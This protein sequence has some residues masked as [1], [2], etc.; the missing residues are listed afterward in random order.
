MTGF[1]WT[2][3]P[4][5]TFAEFGAVWDECNDRTSRSP[6][7]SSTFVGLA[8]KHFGDGTEQVAVAADERGTAAACLL[9][10]RGATVLETFQPSQLPIGPWLQRSDLGLAD[11]AASLLQSGAGHFVMASLTQLDPLLV[12]RPDDDGPIRTVPYIVTGSI[13]LP[14][15]LDE[16]LAGRS[17]NLLANLR[18]RQHKIEREHGPISLEVLDREDDVAEGVGRYSDLESAGWKAKH[19]TALARGNLQWRFYAEAMASFC[20]NN[21]GRVYVLR[22]GDTVAAACLAV[23]AGSTVYLL[24]TTHN[25]Q[26]RSVGP[27][28]ILRRHFVASLYDREPDVRHIEIYGSRNE[29]Q[30][31]WLTGMREMYHVNAYRGP[32]V[33]ALHSLSRRMKQSIRAV[34]EGKR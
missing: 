27:G 8:L 26:L 1:R 11:L 9:R 7:L 32:V 25:E 14:P 30:R 5:D 23:I 22:F 33:A 2:F 13:D 16:Y 15:S 21:Q 18:R 29:S 24:K 19:G 3:C 6:L 20:R 10:K 31:P 12:P 17:E 4:A 28:V 34:A